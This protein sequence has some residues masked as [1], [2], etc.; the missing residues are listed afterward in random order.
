MIV[1]K[2]FPPTNTFVIN[3]SEKSSQLSMWQIFQSKVKI[4]IKKCYFLECFIYTEIIKCY[5]AFIVNIYIPFILHF[6][7]STNFA[8]SALSEVEY[9][10]NIYKTTLSKKIS[11][12]KIQKQ[13]SSSRAFYISNF[14]V[15]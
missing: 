11:A 6:N 2:S 13:Y 4:Q 3:M 14:K 7:E 5:K 10:I 8:H 1:S 15:I 9:G 12:A